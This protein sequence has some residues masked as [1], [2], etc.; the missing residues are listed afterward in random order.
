MLIL[1]TNSIKDTGYEVA[2]SCRWN[3]GDSP[4]MHYTPGSEGNR[5]TWT[6]SCW[7]K[8]SEIAAD[9]EIFGLSSANN[10]ASTFSFIKDDEG[11]L[12]VDH[13]TEYKLVTSRLFRDPSAWY[14]LVL[15]VD[16]TQSTAD[17]RIRLYVNGTQETSFA[18]RNNPDEDE[19]FIINSTTAHYLGIRNY[20]SGQSVPF[21]GYMAEVCMV[22][23]S[24]LAPTSFGEFDEDSPTIWKPIDV[25]GLTF[26]TNGFYLDFEDS[27]NL[28]NDA[29]GGT[30][31]TEVNLAAT[32]QS[33]DSPTNNF[34]T[35]N[36]LDAYLAQGTFSEGNLKYVG[37][38][39]KY[40]FVMSTIMVT[41]GKWYCEAKYLAGNSDNGIVGISG[42]SML[43]L[44]D[45]LGE[46]AG[47]IGYIGSGGRSIVGGTFTSNL[48]A[49]THDDIIGMAMDL[50]NMKMYFA[51]NGT[52]G[53]SGDPTSGAT[54]TGAIT[55]QA[56]STVQHGAYGFAVCSFDSNDADEWFINFGNPPY[57][58]SSDA[59][60]ANGYGA[61][62][63]APPSGYLALCTKNLGSDGG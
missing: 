51:K 59:A 27:A 7:I 60:D 35:L 9:M 15:R 57:A 53:N 3:D 58:N 45:W 25:S 33:S 23:G 11:M 37:V 21:D 30:D 14:H 44:Q 39:T 47:H 28:G 31:L 36:P 40:D 42:D 4:Y 22:D 63:Y 1:G 52:W 43:A 62:E 49:Y 6:F 34:A 13:W 5:K 16:T 20:V 46:Y 26:G 61:F 19:D 41:S 18:T 54:G 56:L 17:D 55:I 12:R 10:N 32:D 38:S 2:N 48:T 8:F 29:N 50:D 24:S